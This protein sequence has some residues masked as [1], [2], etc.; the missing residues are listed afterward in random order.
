MR[1]VVVLVEAK[2]AYLA[3]FDYI[4]SQRLGSEAFQVRSLDSKELQ[5]RDLEVII[6]LPGSILTE[7]QREL[8]KQVASV[9]DRQVLVLSRFS[10]GVIFPQTNV[11]YVNLPANPSEFL[12]PFLKKGERSTAQSD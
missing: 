3:V 12:I 6:D 5:A 2:E 8:V 11:S 4:I 10:E 9:S 1:H 7:M